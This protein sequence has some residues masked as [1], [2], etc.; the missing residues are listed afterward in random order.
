MDFGLSDEQ[1]LLQD[2]LS[3]LLAK[4]APLARTRAFADSGEARADDVWQ[5]LIGLGLPGLLVFLLISF[6]VLKTLWQHRANPMSLILLTTFLTITIHGL[7]DVPFFK[8]DLAMLTALL[9]AA[10][11]SLKTQVREV[12]D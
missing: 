1:V 8:N 12:P 3:R 9:L 6:L 11:I 2:S 7:V 4:H 10:T 5:A